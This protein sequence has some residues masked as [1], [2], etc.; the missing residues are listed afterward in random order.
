M[1]LQPKNT[2]KINTIK[3]NTHISQY[4]IF[5]CIPS[6]NTQ[7]KVLYLYPEFEIKNQDAKTYMY[8][9]NGH[10][11]IC[12]GGSTGR[13]TNNHLLKE[14]DYK[15]YKDSNII[16]VKRDIA[17][18]KPR[19]KQAKGS[20]L[21]YSIMSDRNKKINVYK[22][23]APSRFSSNSCAISTN[24]FTVHPIRIAILIDEHGNIVHIL[25]NVKSEQDIFKAFNI[26]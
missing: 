6:S 20:L 10:Q 1:P 16:M 12:W 14:D 11:V 7:K 5:D 23:K 25:D 3:P 18:I 8:A 9:S 4:S 17:H 21:N 2:P 22:K 19:Y 26:Q 15:K 24:Y 13:I